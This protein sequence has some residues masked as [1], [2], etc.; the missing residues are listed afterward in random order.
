M[1]FVKLL[2]ALIWQLHS[3]PKLVWL[4]NKKAV[5]FDYRSPPMKHAVADQG[6]TMERWHVDHGGYFT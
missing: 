4:C 3:N 1:V 5:Q 6:Q 2:L